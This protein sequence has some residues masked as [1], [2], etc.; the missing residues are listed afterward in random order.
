MIFNIDDELKYSA[1]DIRITM[2]PKYNSDSDIIYDSTKILLYKDFLNYVVNNLP[3]YYSVEEAYEDLEYEYNNS[4]DES[5]RNTLANDFEFIR[6]YRR[7]I[8]NNDFDSSFFSEINI[9]LG[10][11]RYVAP[12]VIVVVVILTLG[13]TLAFCFYFVYRKKGKEDD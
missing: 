12:I 13:I 3:G 5:L 7:F 2:D 8:I 4:L 6:T 11:G 1:F 10:F 9:N